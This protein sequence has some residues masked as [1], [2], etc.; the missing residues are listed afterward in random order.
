MGCSETVGPH[1][2]TEHTHEHAA[3][4]LELIVKRLYEQRP[5]AL[6]HSLKSF[7]SL[8]SEEVHSEQLDLFSCNR[9]GSVYFTDTFTLRGKPHNHQKIKRDVYEE[10][11]FFSPHFKDC[12]QFEASVF[13][14]FLSLLL[15]WSKVCV[16]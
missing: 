16:L 9:S 1:V 3:Q 12:L 4:S 10:L 14:S 2:H 15:S 7:Y 13:L 11:C 5:E 6:A 8:G